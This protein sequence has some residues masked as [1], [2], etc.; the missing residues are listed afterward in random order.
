[1]GFTD[2][3]KGKQYKSELETLQQKYEDLQSLL[4]DYEIATSNEIAQKTKKESLGHLVTYTQQD[5]KM[6][7]AKTLKDILIEKDM[8][9]AEKVLQY[10]LA[11]GVKDI[12]SLMI[13]YYALKEN[14]VFQNIKLKLPKNTPELIEL[15]IN[16]KEYDEL[17]LK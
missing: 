1:M 14:S 3:F 13:T 9:F 5:L 2:I 4:D 15:E 12:K 7:Q 6:M 8:L 16:L 11:K 17:M 10:N